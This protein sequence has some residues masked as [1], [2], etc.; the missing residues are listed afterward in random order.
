MFFC[1]APALTRSENAGIPTETQF[2]GNL[3]WLITNTIQSR[4]FQGQTT[5]YNGLNPYSGLN[6]NLNLNLSP[7]FL[8]VIILEL[9]LNSR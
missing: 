9:S 5:S 6:I 2:V 4:P 8:Y 3:L 7:D 1:I